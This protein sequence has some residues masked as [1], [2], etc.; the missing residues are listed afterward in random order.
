[1][2][3]ARKFSQKSYDTFDSKIKDIVINHIKSKGGSIDRSDEDYHFDIEASYRGKKFY[4]EVEAKSKYRF[5]D[6]QSFPFST[7][8][9]TGRKLRLHKI[10]PF[11]YW[12]VNYEDMIAIV[13]NSN[14]IYKDEYRE[15]LDINTED[16]KGLDEF[17]RV[18]KDE[19]YFIALNNENNHT[20]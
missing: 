12:I 18:P 20:R 15:S 9:F 19:C 13:A 3:N 8:S 11:W 6:I 14:K 7:V 5:K 2:Y 1:M 4:I 10:R 16:R 17:Y